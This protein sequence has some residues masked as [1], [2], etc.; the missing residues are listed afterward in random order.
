M[1]RQGVRKAAQISAPEHQI[2]ATRQKR[3][4][5]LG[6]CGGRVGIVAV[7][8][9]DDLGAFGQRGLGAGP[10]RGAI[11][12]LVLDQHARATGARDGGGRVR[13][14]AHDDQDVVDGRA[15]HFVE[16]RTD[17]LGFVPG[18]DHERHPGSA[19]HAL[20]PTAAPSG[21]I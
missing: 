3:S 16:H 14:A 4:E 18:R 2:G 5:E 9:G 19:G 11:P 7:E 17:R 8:E 1:R 15:R 13:R 12:G 20:Q 6:Q 10:A 21:V